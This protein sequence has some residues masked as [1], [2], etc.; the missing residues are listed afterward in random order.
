M[1]TV[2][3]KVGGI[4][5]TTTEANYKARISNAR[6]VHK[7]Q[8]FNSAEEIIEYFCKYFGSKTEDF[9]IINR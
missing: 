7:M 3:Y 1:K 6:L 2:I 9:I 5:H 4:Y 8:D